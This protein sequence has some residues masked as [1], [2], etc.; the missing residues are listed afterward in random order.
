M[1]NSMP[2]LA[3]SEHYLDFIRSGMIHV[4]QGKVTDISATTATVMPSNDKIEDVAAVILATGFDPSASLSFLPPAVLNAI[5]YDPSNVTLPAALAFH[6]THHP[7]HPT[8]GFVGF[9]RSPYWGV[10]EMQARFVARLLSDAQ[11]SPSIQQVLAH[12]KSIEHIL[13]L[14]SDPRTA[15]FP[16][17]DYPF[18]MQEFG[19]AL[20]I[21]MSPLTETPV[22]PDGS[23]MDIMTPAR[24][25][26][27][28]L[29]AEQQQEV[30]MNLASTS[31]TALA[32]LTGAKFVAHAVFRSLLGEWILERDLVSRLPS[33]PS[34]RFVGVAKFLLRE[35][36]SDGRK[37][38]LES[39]PG[40]EYLYIEDGDF[41][42]SNG[43]KFR[44]TRRYVWRFSEAMDTLSV[45]FTRT[46]DSSRAD[47]LFHNVEFII[48]EKA[49]NKTTTAQGW[50]AKASHLCIED[51]YNV[52]YNFNFKAVNLQKWRLA[53][54]VNGPKKDYTIDGT[55]RRASDK[56]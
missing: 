30:N 54:T 44:A 14:R 1:L 7:S 11:L 22:L 10:M 52:Q 50:Q 39:D 13:S 5:S 37:L 15:Q 48:P 40:M 49:K 33:H 12:D 23:T 21:A 51:M 4:S 29:S 34:G 36:T 55:Y 42:A 18:I 2:Y 47:Y 6:G 8:L 9:Y 53:Y 17:G 41:T 26:M 24:Y 27:P 43:M 56:P 32:G 45:W 28:N 38:A 20:D 3:L 35:G 19:K 16:T 31:E 46:D 25:P